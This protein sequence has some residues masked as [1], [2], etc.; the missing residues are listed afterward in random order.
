MGLAAARGTFVFFNDADDWLGPRAVELML[1]HADRWAS[2][3]LLVRMRSEGGR[4]VPRMMFLCNQPSVDPFESN[5][6][7]T[8]S[9]CKMFRRDF[10]QALGLQFAPDCMPE[11]IGF[12][13]RAYAAAQTVSIAADYDYYHYYYADGDD[14]NLAK[15]SV[16]ANV[17]SN[18][19]AY[20]DLLGLL[21]DDSRLLGSVALRRRLLKVD[22]CNTIRTIA[23][24]DDDKKA[25]DQIGELREIVGRYAFGESTL[26]ILRE[27]ALPGVAARKPRAFGR[28]I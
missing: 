15:G 5:V 4:P 23:D 20:R 22:V 13:I 16:W 21:A 3:M 12:V 7:W 25:L 17:D 11:D 10:V 8:L 28:C 27:E 6:M 19:L 1:D 26:S 9:P 2:D 18:L 14:G 24:A